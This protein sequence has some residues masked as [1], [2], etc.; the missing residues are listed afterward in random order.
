MAT[1]PNPPAF[2]AGESGGQLPS[3]H[4]S[5]LADHPSLREFPIEEATY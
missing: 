3:R 2:L 5:K 4:D 1:T